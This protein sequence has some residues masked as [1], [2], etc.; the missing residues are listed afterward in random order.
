[1]KTFLIIFS[2]IVFPCIVFA[3][4]FLVCDPYANNNEAV[5]YFVVTGLPAEID[6]SHI[7]KDA[8]GQYGF[9]F[10]LSGVA[11]GGPYTV[12]AK[13]CNSWGCSQDSLPFSFSRPVALPTPVGPKLTQ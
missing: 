5:D 10:D 2:I 11:V 1:M 4:P 8:T 3:S 7:S 6:A 13:A 12:K 9:K